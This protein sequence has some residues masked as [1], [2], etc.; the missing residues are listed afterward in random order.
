MS[1]SVALYSSAPLSWREF[2]AVI[3][4]PEQGYIRQEGSDL[5][6]A[7]ED[8]ER[9]ILLYGDWEVLDP[10]PF[11]EEALQYE[12]HLPEIE[13][14]LGGKPASKLVLRIGHEDGSGLLAVE[15]AYQCAIRWP[16]VVRAETWVMLEGTYVE[17]IYTKDDMERL[18]MERKTFT[19][20]MP[21]TTSDKEEA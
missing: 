19:S 12:E 17:M 6:G 15:F 10:E 13:A 18:L 21:L 8:G 7:I 1:E 3:Q 5:L 9:Y 4:A 14:K 11:W 20:T 16:C 2:N